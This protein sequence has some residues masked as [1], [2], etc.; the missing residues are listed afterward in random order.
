MVKDYDRQLSRQAID[1]TVAL[2]MGLLIQAEKIWLA[3]G[4]NLSYFV[5]EGTVQG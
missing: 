1:L 5:I 3:F 4:Q 2:M